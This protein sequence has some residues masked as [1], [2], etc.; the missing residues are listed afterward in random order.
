MGLIEKLQTLIIMGAVAI[1]LLLGQ[2]PVVS[3]YADYGIVPFLLLMLYGL[4]LTIPL[5]Q[6]R[7]AFKNIKFLGASTAI[8][9]IW[10]P[11]L[12][13]DSA[14]SFCR[15]TRRFGSDSLC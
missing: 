10:T 8:N 11:L 7:E 1:G 13:W 12:A 14:L 6:L 2:F 5:Q 9:F 3:E 4:F 15:I